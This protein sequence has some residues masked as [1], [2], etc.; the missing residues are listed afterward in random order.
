MNLR[1]EGHAEEKIFLQ[2]IGK[3]IEIRDPDSAR[4][5]I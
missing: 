4:F 2:R 1:I 3:E 5:N